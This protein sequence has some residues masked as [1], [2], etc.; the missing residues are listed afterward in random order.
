[1]VNL[2]SWYQRCS[3]RA[4]RCRAMWVLPRMQ[5]TRCWSGRDLTWTPDLSMWGVMVKTGLL[6]NT[7]HTRGEHQCPS[8]DWDG[9]TCHWNS[10]KSSF[11]MR[12]PTD[13]SFQDLEQILVLSLLLVSQQTCWAS[14]FKL[15]FI[16]CTVLFSVLLFNHAYY[17]LGFLFVIIRCFH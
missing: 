1:M 8:M 15:F 9:E 5:L 4:S 3:V 10:P 6:I 17:S 13:A 11:L 16:I 7:H 2:L 14:N 12:E